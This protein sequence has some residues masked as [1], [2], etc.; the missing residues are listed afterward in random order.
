VLDDL[1]RHCVTRST[2]CGLF[3]ERAAAERRRQE[4][5]ERHEAE[6]AEQAATNRPWAGSRPKPSTA[7]RP[8]P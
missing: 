7:F 6:L 8:Q 2:A 4:A 5:Q 3:T 1:G